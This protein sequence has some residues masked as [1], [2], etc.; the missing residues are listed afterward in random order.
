MCEGKN[1]ETLATVMTANADYNNNVVVIWSEQSFVKYP[2]VAR[3][4]RESK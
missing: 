3:N 4:L 2:L 1:A